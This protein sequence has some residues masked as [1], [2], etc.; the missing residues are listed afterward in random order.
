[1]KQKTNE[2]KK[3]KFTGLYFLGAMVAVYLVIFV[4]S[5]DAGL[6]ALDKSLGVLAKLVPIL[7]VVVVLIGLMSHFFNPMKLS[8]H[9]GQESGRHSWLIAVA[10]GILSHGPAYVWYP[11]LKELRDHGAKDG[12][13]VTYLYVR[14]IKLPLLPIMIDYFGWHFVAVLVFWIMIG[15]VFQGWIMELLTRKSN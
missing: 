4:F 14:A 7:T 2:E 12:L 13:L 9:L 1:M 11:L 5:F 8:K 10:G 15:G 6:E 3:Q